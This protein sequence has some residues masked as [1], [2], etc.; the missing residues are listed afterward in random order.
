VPPSA[1]AISSSVGEYCRESI[2]ITPLGKMHEKRNAMHFLPDRI[3]GKSPN[4]GIENTFLGVSRS[5]TTKRQGI[6]DTM[7]VPSANGWWPECAA[8]IPFQ[9]N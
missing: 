6:R 3:C 4:G 1:S 8:H 9:M 7:P 2:A 5:I